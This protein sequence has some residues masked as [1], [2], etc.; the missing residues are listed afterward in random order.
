MQCHLSTAY[1]SGLFLLS[2]D[3]I[4][5]NDNAQSLNKFVL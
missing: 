5:L 4:A 1:I 2:V 3:Y